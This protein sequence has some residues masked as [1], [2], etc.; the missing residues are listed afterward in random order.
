M[1]ASCTPSTVA[2]VANI[3]KSAKTHL[4]LHDDDKNNESWDNMMGPAI[5]GLAGLTLASQMAV[6]TTLDVSSVASTSS[7]IDSMPIVLRQGTLQKQKV[8]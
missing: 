4:N 2:F 7:E 1:V 8:K 5:A 6:A 3:Q